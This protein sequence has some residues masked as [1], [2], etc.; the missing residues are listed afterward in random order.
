MT[1]V[2][3]FAINYRLSP[4]NPFPAAIDDA[5]KGY[6]YLLQKGYN[7]KKIFIAG[8]SAGGGLTVTTLL[9]LKEENIPLPAAAI[10][11]APWTDM[12]GKSSSLVTNAKTELLLEPT[13]IDMWAKAYAGTESLRHPLVSPIH[14][15]LSGL[16][17]LYIQVSSSEMLLDDAIRLHEHALA[18]GVD[19]TL[20][21]WNGLIHVWHVHTF[22]PEAR[23]AI[24]NIAA[25]A[26]KHLM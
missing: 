8:D 10:C 20:E 2:K 9:K 4:E 25:F 1:R 21:I 19:S 18:C 13:S 16:P 7:P 23:Q 22:L 12:E 26:G 24:R 5:V 15:D 3:A 17:P 6:Q 14:A 11:I